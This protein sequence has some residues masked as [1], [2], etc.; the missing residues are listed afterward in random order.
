MVYE[1][2]DD[3]LLILCVLVLGQGNVKGYRSAIMKIGNKFLNDT[4]GGGYTPCGV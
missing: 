1:T 4:K 2:T 3:I